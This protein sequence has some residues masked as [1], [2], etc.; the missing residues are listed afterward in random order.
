[1]F[2]G[3]VDGA[4]GPSLVAFVKEKRAKPADQTDINFEN[5]CGIDELIG[6][7]LV[8]SVKRDD[9]GLKLVFGL[10]GL[11]HVIQACADDLIELPV[12]D[13]GELLTPQFAELLAQ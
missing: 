12:A 3:V 6:Q 1:M 11:P 8:G 13:V 2:K 5:D 4:P 10:Q 7:Y 9:S